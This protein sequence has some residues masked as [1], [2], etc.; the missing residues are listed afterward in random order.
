M[1]TLNTEVKQNWF[2]TLNAALESEDLLDTWDCSWAPI[3]YGKTRTY[4]YD[5]GSRYGRQVSIYRDEM[6][7][8][9]RPVHYSRG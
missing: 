5:D 9:E 6:G 7:R 2:P 3:N 4:R 1:M 8:Y